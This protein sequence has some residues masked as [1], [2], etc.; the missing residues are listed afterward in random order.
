MLASLQKSPAED[1]PFPLYTEQTLLSLHHSDRAL[2]KLLLLV[3][4]CLFV[5]LFLLVGNAARK[6]CF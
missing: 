5:C 1:I 2:N 4:F 6:G 3:G